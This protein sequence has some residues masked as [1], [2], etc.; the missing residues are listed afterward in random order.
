MR[1]RPSSPPQD[2]EKNDANSNEKSIVTRLVAWMFPTSSKTLKPEGTSQKGV[3]ASSPI[4]ETPKYSDAESRQAS[5]NLWSIYISEAERYDKA[6][7]ESWKADMEGML[8]FSGLFS[9]SLTAFLVESYQTLQPDSGTMTVQL[10]TQISQQLASNSTTALATSE[11]L[12]FHPAPSSLIC[13]ALWF[14]SLSLSITCALLATL[15]EQWA[16]EFLH[17]TERKPSPIQRA[18]I[19]SFL[20]FGVR[21]F[22]MHSMVDLIPLLL[23]VSLMLFLAGLVA[24][25]LPINH[26]IM[27]L[28]AAI[29][30]GFLA[31]Y[32]ILTVLPAI[33][34][35]SPY[36]TPFSNLVWRLIHK[37]PSSLLPRSTSSSASPSTMDDAMVEMALQPSEIRDQRALS[38]TLDSLTDNAEFLPFL[39]SIPEALY[40]FAGFHHRNDYLFIHLLDNPANP[41]RISGQPAD[42]DSFS[43][44]ITDFLLSCQ[45]MAV[46][47]PLRKRQLIAGM[48][49][50]WALGMI[51]DI[52]YDRE[53][54]GGGFWFT[55]RTGEAVSSSLFSQRKPD[56]WPVSHN[57]SARTA[58]GYS[59]MNNLRTFIAGV[60][61][62][63]N[64]SK[65]IEGVHN[66]IDMAMIIPG[67]RRK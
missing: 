29:L 11:V 48:K 35:D 18:Q 55:Q 51:S 12:V 42:S 36:R 31:V 20:Y 28:I 30:A 25:L 10:L 64:T 34:L 66:V 59:R 41:Y 61:R 5:A 57:S 56:N 62:L 19:F 6:L 40:G 13:N 9:A 14:I 17:R 22:G 45:N 49:A 3:P 60:S 43:E 52:T 4:H 53:S 32:G 63:D 65:L 67:R 54:S 39:E 8:I 21:R 7:V 58:I 46:D 33:S 16:R 23:H 44:R 37:L 24:F 38:W 15:I 2:P 27:G 47:D 50:V 1:P 26:I